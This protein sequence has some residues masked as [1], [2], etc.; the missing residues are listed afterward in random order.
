[1]TATDN[2]WPAVAENIKKARR[3]WGRL[4][5]V[6]DREGAEHK[7]SRTFYITVTQQ[8]LIF[9]AETWVLTAKMEKALD[10]FQGRVVGKITGRHTR[11]RRD[12]EWF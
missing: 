10:T 11:R 7:V 4:A 2:N 9:G 3:R 8:V 1:M 6:L 12:G 5:K